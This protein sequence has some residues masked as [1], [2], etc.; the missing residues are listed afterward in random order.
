MTKKTAPSSSA[1]SVVWKRHARQWSY[2]GPPLRPASEDDALVHAAI[3]RWLRETDRSDATALV[4]GVTPELCRA[5]LDAN[6]RVIAVDNSYDMIRAIWPGRIR[7]RDEAVCA[8]WRRMPFDAS[9]VDLAFADGTFSILQYPAGYEVLCDE[10]RRLLRPGGPCV[11]RCFAQ[12][13]KRETL[14]DV[15]ADLSAGRVGNFHILKWRLA[16]ALQPSAEAGVSVGSVWSA[17]NDAWPDL[18]RLAEHTGWPVEQV[19]TIEVYRGVETRYTFPTL[20]EYCRVF[21]SAGWRVV[22]VAVPSY[23]LGERCPTL[24]IEPLDGEAHGTRAAESTRPDA[25]WPAPRD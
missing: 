20:E 13:E 16:M 24:V 12:V 5:T 23:E 22:D 1:P 14:E 6:S 21:A 9:S 19:R 3:V 11:V 15:F 17:L 8:D 2:V 25:A 4:L 10:L 18:D 7:A